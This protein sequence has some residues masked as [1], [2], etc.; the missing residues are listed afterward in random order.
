MRAESNV[1]FIDVFEFICKGTYISCHFDSPHIGVY[2]EKEVCEDLKNY[3]FVRER[4]GMTSLVGLSD[5]GI[6]GEAPK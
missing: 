4:M 6:E 2:A 1:S 5:L 3:K